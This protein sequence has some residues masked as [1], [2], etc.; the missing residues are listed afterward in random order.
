ML[1]PTIYIPSRL[2]KSLTLLASSRPDLLPLAAELLYLRIV[3]GP[4]PPVGAEVGCG[5]L[6]SGSAVWVD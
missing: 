6:S 2:T 1:R 3:A 4:V 5:C